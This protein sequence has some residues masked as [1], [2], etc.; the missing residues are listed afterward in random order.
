M[1]IPLASGFPCSSEE[2]WSFQFPGWIL[3]PCLAYFRNEVSKAGEK[4]AFCNCLSSVIRNRLHSDLKHKC[5][6]QK[7]SVLRNLKPKCLQT[8]VPTNIKEVRCKIALK[9]LKI[10]TF[11]LF[12]GSLSTELRVFWLDIFSRLPY[13][14]ISFHASDK[15]LKWTINSFSEELHLLR[16]SHKS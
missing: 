13:P 16:G 12:D 4:G 5:C 1:A 7:L 3:F 2:R 9:L 14:Q 15:L 10:K 6:F 8:V 11:V